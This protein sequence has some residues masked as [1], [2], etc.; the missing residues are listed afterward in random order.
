[1]DDVP[2]LQAVLSVVEVGHGLESSRRD[3][4][5]QTEG[6]VRRRRLTSSK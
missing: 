4:L 2:Q 3:V 1:V 5:G 6:L